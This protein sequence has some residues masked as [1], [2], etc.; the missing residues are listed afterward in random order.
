M[1]FFADFCS[2]E[3]PYAYL[4]GWYCCNT[5]EERDPS[6]GWTPPEEVASGTCDGIDFNRESTCCKD[7]YEPCPSGGGCYDF[8]YKAGNVLL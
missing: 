7:K 2:E 4:V 3:F 5:N 6:L 1:K 8:Q